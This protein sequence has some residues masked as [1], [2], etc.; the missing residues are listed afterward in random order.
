M[1]ATATTRNVSVRIT[2]LD[3]DKARR[4]L[5]LTGEAGQRALQKIKD[6]SVPA[7]RSLVAINAVSQEVSYGLHGVAG[8]AGSV[9][10]VLTRL[11]PIGIA[12][13]VVL[14][15]ITLAASK[16]IKEFKEAAGALKSFNAALAAT[17]SVSGVTA[18]EITELGEAVEANTLFKKEDILHAA[19]A[20]TSFQNVSGEVFTRTLSLASDMAVRLGTDIPSAAE[21]LGRSLERP[22]DGLGRLARK[23]SDLSPTQKET[24][25]NFV[26]QGDVAAA[27]A[28]ILE[29][30]EGKTRELAEAQTKGLTGA[31]NALGDAWDDLMESFGGTLVHTGV[32]QGGLSMLTK[33]VRGLHAA[34]YPTDEQRKS[35]LEEDIAAMEDSFGTRLDRWVLG[36]APALDA[37]KKELKDLNAA[38]A[39]EERKAQE[40]KQKALDAADQASATRRN[41]TLLQI[42]KEYQKKLRESTQTERE[43]IMQEAAEAKERID[44]LYKDDRNS[45]AARGARDAVDS[46]TRAKLAKL[47][48]EAAKP[49]Q[50]LAEANR[51]VVESLSERLRLEQL[52]EKER[53][54]QTEIGK[55]N[56]SATAEQVRAIRQHADALY[57]LK[58]AQEAAREAERE[59]TRQTEAATRARKQAI[60]DINDRILDTMPAYDAAI[61]AAEDWRKR[62]LDTLSTSSADY[63]QYAGQ[64]DA[65]FG[66]MA[67]QALD[68]SRKMEDGITRGLRKYAEEATDAA[69]S[70]EKIIGNAAES[71]ESTLVDAFTNAGFSVESFGKIAQSVA[72]DILQA[73]IRQ[74]ITGPLVGAINQGISGGSSGGGLGGF[75]GN[76]LSSI[77]HDGGKVGETAAPTR[78][79]PAAMFATAPR[80]HNGLQPDEFPAILQK[81]ETV[82]PRGTSPVQSQPVEVQVINVT[83]PDTVRTMVSE[84][85]T[86]GRTRNVIVNS[87]LQAMEQRGLQVRT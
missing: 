12:A 80:F 26:R 51:K 87:V 1:A 31:S 45:D 67:E 5:T 19:A 75:F 82:L 47:D 71:V 83:N 9:G 18:R 30:L 17:D 56:A 33:A 46:S 35:R 73:Y 23:F 65:V 68:K 40:E 54:I 32:A 36:S 74:N 39:E 78:M 11:G 34:L 6:A 70:A 63:E 81:G 77:F 42:E 72:R 69:A 53:F 52:S 22:E 60:E 49:A 7:S 59:A 15:G 14:G 79:M 21:M 44:A 10:T 20:L 37:K 2:V 3:G 25:E 57:E 58:E 66:H 61:K 76:I 38:M 41:E 62:T 8:N 29:H 16:G 24:I 27:Q 28:I 84:A 55:L 4:E 48:T 13:A 86:S 50:Q 85:M 64:V 43:K